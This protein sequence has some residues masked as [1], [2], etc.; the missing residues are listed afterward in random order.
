[1]KNRALLLFA[2][3]MVLLLVVDGCSR[4]GM[5]STTTEV[6]D[7]VRVKEVPRF[8]SVVIPGRNVTL[9]GLIECDPVANKPKPFEGK[10]ESDKSG[11]FSANVGVKI[12]SD[13]QLVATGGCDS[14][15]KEIEVRDKEIYRLRREKTR[16][17]IPVYVTSDF[18]NFC[19]WWFASTAVIAIV[20]IFHKLK[21]F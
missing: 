17:E 21:N 19:R 15:K 12:D 14:L 7:S 3:M 10:N 20:T 18:D 13:G 6:S 5:S 16:E 2:G 9:R 11:G 4:K 1:M 8:I